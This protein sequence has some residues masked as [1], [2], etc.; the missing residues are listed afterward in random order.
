MLQNR[1]KRVAIVFLIIFIS[2]VARMFYIQIISS[3]MLSQKASAQRVSNIE[4]ENVR[5]DFLD[6]NGIRFTSRIAKITAVLKPLLLKK[7]A[8]ATLIEIC[9]LTGLDAQKT[10]EKIRTTKNP[11]LIDVDQETRALI[12]SKNIEGISFVNSLDRYGTDTKAKHILGYINQV[13][14]VGSFGLEKQYESILNIGKD[15]TIGVVTDAN[16]NLLDGLGYR[17]I[18]PDTK[19]NKKLDIQLT[20]DYHIQSIIENALDKRGL[21]GAVVVEDVSNGN[22]VGICSKP[23]FNPNDVQNY[24]NNNKQPLYNRAL[25]QYNI[26]SIFKLVDLA[27]VYEINPSFNEIYNCTG[28]IQV[29]NSLIRCSS[30][31]KG[32]HG[33]IDIS[34]ALANSCNSYF[35]N[36]SMNLG[37]EPILSMA[38]SLGLGKTTGLTL[39]KIDEAKGVLPNSKDIVNPGDLANISIGQ[40]S[41]LATPVQIADMVA[42]IAIG[43]NKHN[44]NIVN[45]V[46]DNE[47][48]KI[49][50]L[51]NRSETR[52]MSKATAQ[53]IRDLMVGVIRS[54]T[55]K[56]ANLDGYGGAGGKTGSAETGQLIEGEKV[57]Q[58]WFA[59]FFPATKPK[60]SVAIFIENGKSGSEAAA[61]L[62]QEIGEE[63]IKKG[64]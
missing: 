31:E 61:P 38:Q 56:K 28:Y 42:T 64:L 2:L 41:V 49:R 43:G 50:D 36:F 3:S 52:V 33:E 60:Y 54:G 13:D 7:E 55:G 18:K 16:N 59:G 21:T 8:D 25:A 22:I 35:I 45:C 12:M 62:F 46:T 20:L 57:T 30:Y 40:G 9:S 5:G 1:L 34:S 44:V 39:Q 23:D 10:I 19:Q 26:G 14:N 24:L 15:T 4:I 6:R 63:I 29:G 58:A 48:N 51:A 17:V 32:G 11:I 47:G 37:I 53:S 27:A